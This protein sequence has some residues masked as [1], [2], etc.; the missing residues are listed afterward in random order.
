MNINIYKESSKKKKELRKDKKYYI[1]L[2]MNGIKIK[3]II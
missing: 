3:K 2:H 1:Y